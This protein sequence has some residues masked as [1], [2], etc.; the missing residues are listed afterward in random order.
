MKTKRYLDEHHRLYFISL[1]LYADIEIFSI[2]STTVN[3]YLDIEYLNEICIFFIHSSKNYI[4]T[5]I[6]P[7]CHRIRLHNRHEVYFAL[8]DFNAVGKVNL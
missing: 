8:V 2:S 6:D 3:K 1:G 4:Y 5:V 7:S